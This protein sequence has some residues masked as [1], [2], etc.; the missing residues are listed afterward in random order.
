MASS[1]TGGLLLLAG[2]CCLVPI[3][4][5]EGLQGHAVQETDASQHDRE[6]HQEA[7]CHKIAPNLVDFAFSV[8]RRAA[9]E[10]NATNVFFSP[11]S[12]ATAFAMLSLGTKGDTHTEILEGLDFNLTA[13]TEAE[14]HEGFQH[15]L[16]TLN[17]PDNQLQLTTG[18]GLFVNETAKLVAKFLDDVKNLY[19]SEAFSVNFRDAEEAKKKIN[20][21]VKKGS[22]GKIVDLVDDL[23]QD[24]VFAL[25]NYIFFKGKWEKPFEEEHTTERDFHVDEET[26][27]KVPMMNRQ[28]MFDLHYCD[29]LSSWVLLMDYVGNA[30]ALFILPDQGKLQH[31]EDQLSKGL[32]AKFLEKRYASSANLHLPKLSI[33]GTYDLKTLL[34]KLGITKV[35]SNG[36][37]LSGITEEVPLKLSKAVHKAVLTIDEKGTEATGATI[38]EAIPMSIPPEVEYNRPFFFIIYDKSSQAPLFVGKVVNPTQK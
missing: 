19:H 25:V 8:Y 30:T 12:I 34:G 2:L 23:D 32:L 11:V 38:L 20:D 24:T 7:A 6:R 14:I 15:L 37:D 17:Q 36:A 3:S 26:T 33:S 28:G 27:V 29:R 22:Q 4:L 16:H 21:Y 18:N 10:S 31:L 9:R 13:R 1:I 5:A 35:F